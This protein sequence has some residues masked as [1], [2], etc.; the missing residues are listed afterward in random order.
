MGIN[1]HIASVSFLLATLTI[2]A[3]QNTAA[4][5]AQVIEN[6]PS[7][8][9][10]LHLNASSFVSGET[11]FYKIYSLNPV[12]N[13][14]SDV[15]KIAYVELIDIQKNS[16]VKQ[17]L[18]LKNGLAQSDFF[19][20]ASLKTGNYKLVAYTNWMLNKGTSELFQQEIFILNP[21]EDLPESTIA[22]ENENFTPSEKKS[23]SSA[24]KTTSDLRID[25]NKK[26]FKQRDEAV[27]NIAVSS[28]L[29]GNYSVSVRKMDS[30][31]SPSMQSSTDFKPNAAKSQ[32]AINSNKIIL[33]E[34]RGE[35]I[36]GKI[37]AGD[38][39]LQI[40]NVAVALSIPG[41]SFVF[42]IVRT[43][44]QGEFF[45]TIDQTYQNPEYIIQVIGEKNALYNVSINTKET[46]NYDSLEFTNTLKIS[47]SLKNNLRE[48]S[49]SSQVENA[50]FSK[51]T[52]SLTAIATKLFF[53]PYS[54]S[55]PLDDYTRFSTLK[56][57]VT[58]VVTEMSYTKSRGKYM[59]HLKDFKAQEQVQEP[60]LTLVDGI[61]VQ[62]VTDIAE[63]EAK[64]IEKI[65][66]IP[67]G[68]IYGGTITSGYVSIFTKTG[69]FDT[70]II[71]SRY[72]NFN[73]GVA[74]QPE[75]IYFKQYYNAETKDNRIPDFRNQLLWL[76]EVALSEKN[77]KISFF[78]SDIPGNYEISIEGFTEN[79]KPISTKEYF[80][81][82]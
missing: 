44:R 49:I 75:K 77:N 2:S 21:F 31:P 66:I 17:K 41:K 82:K 67:K 61:L 13:K 32:I 50:Y 3:Q 24:A 12:N 1:K 59:F 79:G 26:V 56:Q 69:D 80:E 22:K 23:V 63:Y 62:D 46:I 35:L 58:E 55:Y 8:S 54:K 30:L 47:P 27:L 34:M 40:N 10:F 65:N 15:S 74:P 25:L 14:A 71:T 52:D 43:N 37:E 57:T 18:F 51:K 81:V 68:Y 48:R 9:L 76:P 11:L 29:S 38:K 20:P 73:A 6:S 70:D 16:I 33:P 28:L 72:F 39:N 53:D 7:E 4:N 5:T 64:N 36:T 78:T 19:I 42:K 60:I 45:F